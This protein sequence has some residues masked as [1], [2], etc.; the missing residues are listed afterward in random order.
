MSKMKKVNDL[1]IA[2]DNR[3]VIRVP[4]EDNEKAKDK[5]EKQ[6]EGLEAT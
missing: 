2:N 4:E 5:F 1:K 6:I 3:K